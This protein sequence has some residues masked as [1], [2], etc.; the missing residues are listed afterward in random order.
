MIVIIMI[1][2]IIIIIL[3]ITTTTTTV[4]NLLLLHVIMEQY[5][6]L[7]SPILIIVTC[8]FNRISHFTTNRTTDTFCI[9]YITNYNSYHVIIINTSLAHASTYYLIF[10]IYCICIVFSYF[11]L[12][13]I[14]SQSESSSTLSKPLTQ[15]RLI[16]T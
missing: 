16:F 3:L 7:S 6:V 14:E 4:S 2:I 1:I 12:F 11:Q 15:F 10:T 9:S 13:T 5:V 8:L